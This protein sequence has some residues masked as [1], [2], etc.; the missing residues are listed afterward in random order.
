M[1]ILIYTLYAIK[2]LPQSIYS[3]RACRLTIL[4]HLRL[5]KHL[6]REAEQ[7]IIKDRSC[8]LG[9]KRKYPGSRYQSIPTTRLH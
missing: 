6:Y 3:G 2:Y 9:S 7:L 5:R 8:S 4:N 1:K